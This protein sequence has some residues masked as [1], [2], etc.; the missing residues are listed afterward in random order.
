MKVL[1]QASKCLGYANCMV[2]APD[3]FEV[4]DD[5]GVVHLLVESPGEEQREAVERAVADCPTR[6]IAIEEDA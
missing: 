1:V 3:V 5:D 2:A 4:G 6:A